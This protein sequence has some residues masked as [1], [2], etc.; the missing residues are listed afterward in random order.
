MK[1]VSKILSQLLPVFIMVALLFFFRSEIAITVLAIFLILITFKRKY[2][3]KEIYVF[4]F[5][6]AMGIFFELTGNFLLEQSWGEASFFTIPIWLPLAWGYG[7]V[8]IRRI[9]NII[10]GAEINRSLHD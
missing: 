6:T 7:F 9:G 8:I 10:V 1:K 4:L 2:C 5:G 3:K